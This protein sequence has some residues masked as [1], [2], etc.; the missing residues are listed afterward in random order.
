M[1]LRLVLIISVLSLYL[2]SLG[3]TQITYPNTY[4]GQTNI[5]YMNKTQV[6]KT[7]D[8]LLAKE[9]QI[10]IR[11]NTYN[12]KPQ[13][14]GVSIDKKTTLQKIYAPNSFSF[15]KNITTFISSIF[16]ARKIDPDLVFTKD[17]FLFTENISFDFVTKPDSIGVDN[18]GKSFIIEE[19]NEKKFV[20]DPDSLRTLITQHISDKEI[21]IE[22]LLSE[23]PSTK[24]VLLAQYNK[25]IDQ[26]FSEPVNLRITTGASLARI[27]I[28]P[29]EIRDIVNLGYDQYSNQFTLGIDEKKLKDRI[30]LNKVSYVM[31][32]TDATL[33][34]KTIKEALVNLINNRLVGKSANSIETKIE[35]KYKSDGKLAEKYIEVD[36]L[37]QKMYLFKEGLM[38]KSYAIT[39]NWD[40][41][42]PIGTFEI[43]NKLDIGYSAIYQRWMPYWMSYTYNKSLNA[44]FGIHETPYKNGSDA[45]SG[46]PVLSA[47]P[48]V[49]GAPETPVDGTSIALDKQSAQEVYL[50]AE[51]GTKVVIYE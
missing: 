47:T 16:T 46:T 7:L 11:E 26:V 40:Y 31:K 21:K 23:I 41:P 2:A 50:F 44:Y 1:H 35:E 29:S 28:N 42:V 20:I 19:E 43:L 5:G 25:K 49:T 12:Y 34:A 38:V 18:I 3:L 13:N 39:T 10:T 48:K 8:K 22:P 30:L 4:I 6:E 51:K 24:A 45:L 9:M 15:G 37:Q 33:S 17:F 27:I 14:I 36:L 32:N